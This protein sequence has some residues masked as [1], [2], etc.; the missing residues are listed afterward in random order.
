MALNIQRGMK[1]MPTK[2][3]VYG[4][5]G[6]GKSS[7]AA[8][9]PSPVFLDTERGTSSLD[10]A[11]IEINNWDELRQ[12]I[13]EI[14]GNRSEFKTV[15]IDSIDW[16]EEM[17]GQAI[18]KE[19]GKASLQDFGYG[20][21]AVYLREGIAKLTSACNALVGVGM[22]VVFIAHAK[23]EKV[24]LPDL[25]DSYD[26]YTINLS[27]HVTPKIKEWCD[28][29]LFCNY[30]TQ[31]VEGKDKKTKAVGGKRRVMYAEC[32]AAWD[33]KN[34]YGLDAELPMTIESLAP[35]FAEPARRPGW[36][37]RVSLAV[38]VAALG[39]IGDDADAAVSTGK[40]SPEQREQL[41]GMIDARHAEIGTEVTA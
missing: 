23:I 6:I 30:K 4:L 29:M 3:L 19:H 10:V 8:A 35:I 21:E 15:V 16:A 24:S 9:F 13:A 31:T 14:G 22:H 25:S 11:R 7:L 36:R 5:P 34:R 39:R 33:A 41:D 2:G 28:V 17:L 32:A 20:K 37:D 38:P 1:W 12:A 27:K 18:C 40:L 26:R